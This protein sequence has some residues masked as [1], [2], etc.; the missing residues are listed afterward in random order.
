MNTNRR[1]T[2]ESIWPDL[3]NGLNQL[4]F[5]LNQGI[6][7]EYWMRLYTH[8]YQFCMDNNK[9][10]CKGADF[11]GRELYYSLLNFLK[12]YIKGLFKV[13]EATPDD[14]LLQHYKREWDRFNTS[15]KYINH[16][17]RYLREQLELGSD[18]EENEVYEIY[19]LGLVLW[20]RYML[21][22]IKDRLT[23]TLLSSIER[24]RNGEQVDVHLIQ[25][26]IKSY[27][28]LLSNNSK[29]SQSNS[30]LYDT[31]FSE[32]LIRATERYYT[33]ESMQF[34]S[35]NTISSYMEKISKRLEEEEE[36]VKT[37]LHPCMAS[38]LIRVV[39]KVLIDQHKEAIWQ[40]FPKILNEDKVEDLARMYNLFSRIS[41]A[42]DPLRD[43]FEEHV[44]HAG[45]NEVS[46]V[47]STTISN[48]VEYVT[49]LLNVHKKYN[50]LVVEAFNSD[51]GFVAS[52]DRAC[53]KFINDNA[54]TKVH[55]STK[56]PELIAKYCD[57]L[58]KKSH[59]SLE[60][61]ETLET[62]NN[63]MLLFKY[64]ED[65]DVFQ[66]FYSKMLAKRLIHGTSSSMHLEV[67]VI[68]KLK[69]NCG[70]E[71]TSKLTRMFSE[72]ELSKELQERFLATINSSELNSSS[73]SILVLGTSFWPL[74]APVRS[75]SI[76]KELACW[77]QAFSAFYTNEFNGR[78][79]NWLHQL[80]KGDL[81]FHCHQNPR[82]GYVLQCSVYQMAILLLFNNADELTVEDLQ[83]ATQLNDGTLRATILSLLKTK[84]LCSQ[85]GS[86]SMEL[87]KR[88]VLVV[89]PNFKSKRARVMVN[90]FFREEQAKET[91]EMQQVI[92]EGR[93]NL[94]Q[95][96]IVRIMKG[97]KTCDHSNLISEVILQLQNRFKPSVPLIKKCIDILIEKEYLERD[98]NQKDIYNYK[99]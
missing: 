53:S 28:L 32:Q 20:N 27:V 13:A 7:N 85:S 44:Y 3:E 34:I 40:E 81:R 98:E 75:F 80:C 54:V 60:E 77:E 10:T 26:V 69:Q 21:K 82:N 90:V 83:I 93:Y 16:V 95:A 11:G 51:T 63:V 70:Y 86:G 84:V 2:L 76:P 73:F 78:K 97:R 15:M 92:E 39:E 94:V 24:E 91:V 89:N 99:P 59:K 19:F 9:G 17:F 33:A 38:D 23:A 64:I 48:P 46:A 88:Q 96:S 29:K 31:K 14:C 49:A 8:V 71:Y 41:Y 36:R 62:L 87:D 55:G 50:S 22:E 66:T 18:D 68:S 47:Q 25:D 58:L 61:Q 6:S 74:Q 43:T 45:L 67:Q 1:V 72:I 4:L 65:K 56:S 35:E 42:I 52:L 37:Y 30:E 79:L 57:T 12:E 5:N